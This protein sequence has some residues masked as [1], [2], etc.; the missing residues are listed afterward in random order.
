FGDLDKMHIGDDIIIQTN[1]GTVF[2]YKMYKQLIVKATDVWVVANTPDAELTLTACHPKGSAA[3]RIVVKAKLVVQK[4]APLTL[5]PK[6]PANGPGKDRAGDAT[7]AEGL[8][9]QQRSLAP[10]I[11]W[12]II[13]ALVGLAWW[14]AY[15]RWRHPS[16]WLI[17]VVPFLVALFPF[18]VYLERALP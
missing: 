17:G 12:G 7:L 16:T 18:Y 1:A 5:S 3:E 10:S 13:V 2:E 11:V 14:W 15:R 9:G 6:R 4:S 8:S